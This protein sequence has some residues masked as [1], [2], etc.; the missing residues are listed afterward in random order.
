VPINTA[1]KRRSISSLTGPALVPG[2]TP[3]VSKGQEWRQSA[4]WGYSG[5]P[6]DDPV[7]GT[8]ASVRA[9]VGGG[10]RVSARAGGGDGGA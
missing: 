4:G 1:V 3:D 5:L 7:V 9:R 10:S 8:G 2:V 6:G